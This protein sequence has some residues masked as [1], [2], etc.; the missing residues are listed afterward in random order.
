[1][2]RIILEEY[3]CGNEFQYAI[4]LDGL[5]VIT[6][7]GF[8]DMIK[9][10]KTMLQHYRYHEKIIEPHSLCRDSKLFSHHLKASLYRPQV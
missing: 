4:S 7:T 3:D 6:V 8:Q 1:M 10:L 2:V 9:Y 5:K